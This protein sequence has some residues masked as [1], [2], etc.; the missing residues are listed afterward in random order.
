MGDDRATQGGIPLRAASSF[1]SSVGECSH[2]HGKKK[3]QD[4]VVRLF[5]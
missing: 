3:D 2:L 1:D 5:D 4:E